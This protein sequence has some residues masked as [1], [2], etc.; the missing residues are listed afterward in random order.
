[1]LR[2]FCLAVC[3]QIVLPCVSSAAEARDRRWLI[4]YVSHP[5]RQDARIEKYLSHIN[6][7]L[8]R[9]GE[10]YL[11]LDVEWL[12][13]SGPA[14]ERAR[15]QTNTIGAL[16]FCYHTPGLKY[17]QDAALLEKL[18][19]AFLAVA[20]HVTPEGRF[21]WPNDRDMYW[22]GSHEH[23]WRLEPLL[24]GYIWIGHRFPEADRRLI[25]A[26][27]DRAAKWLV[28]HPTLEHNNRGAAWCAITTLCGLYFERPE[29]LLPVEQHAGE[30]MNSVVLE[31]GEVGEHTSQYSDGGPCTN[32]SFTGISYV[33]LYR[34]LSG[35]D[36]L[37]Q[38]LQGAAKWFSA[39]MTPAGYPVVAGASVRRAYSDPGAIDALPLLERYSRAEPFLSTMA[40][41]IL[42]G[43]CGFQRHIISPLIWAML[44][45]R[46]PAASQ[47]PAWFANHTQIYDRPQVGYAL[48]GRTYRTGVTLRGTMKEGNNFHLRGLQTFAFDSERPILHHTDKVHSTILADGIDTAETNVTKGPAGWEAFLSRTPQ[49][50]DAPDLATLVERRGALWTIYAVTP[51]SFVVVTGGAKGPITHRWALGRAGRREP[52]LDKDVCRVTFNDRKGQIFFRSG[53]AQIKTESDAFVMEVVAPTGTNA[54]A[55]ARE[56][57]G[58]GPG[59]EDARDLRFHD[60]SGHYVLSLS[61]PVDVGGGDLS[62]AAPMRLTRQAE[63][64]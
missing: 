47:P 14:G 18:R 24:I 35:R 59:N 5:I 52:T 6:R 30:I 7:R 32:Y 16:A 25:E 22:A 9:S 3:I 54:F 34:L 37:D 12:E 42:R 57:F 64:P 51:V 27:L 40:D 49:A 4:D 26:M 20:G 23:A 53:D 63:E 13:K 29:Y 55:F 33:Y 46:G 38:R 10:G 60:A 48:I 8:E 11:G 43:P 2:F 45:S 15:E 41:T 61:N 50:G 36:D 39:W 28:Q 17:H 19:K 44:E 1:M 58:F 56:G 62:R 21:V 31:D